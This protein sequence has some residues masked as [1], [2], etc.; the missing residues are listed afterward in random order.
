MHYK[1]FSTERTLNNEMFAYYILFLINACEAK[2]LT[3]AFFK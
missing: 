2:N 3:V 1:Y